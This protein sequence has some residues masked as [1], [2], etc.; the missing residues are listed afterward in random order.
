MA[1]FEPFSNRLLSEQM[2]ATE[3]RIIAALNEHEHHLTLA[4]HR[5]IF[6]LESIA[7]TI[8]GP[9]DGS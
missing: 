7:K 1:V 2:A 4:I 8:S 9:S 6:V 5:L 3:A